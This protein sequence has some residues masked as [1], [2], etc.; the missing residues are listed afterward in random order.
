MVIT[1]SLGIL[2]M[3]LTL[4]VFGVLPGVPQSSS[5]TIIIDNDPPYFLASKTIAT[6]GTPIRWENRTAFHHAIIYDAC[7]AGSPCAF[8]V[9]SIAPNEIYTLQGLPPGRYAYHCRLHPIM[10]G[11][12][13]VVDPFAYT[14]M[15]HQ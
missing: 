9:E 14:T 4:F 15:A 11:E 1:M 3:F 7:V 10:R 12:V 8:V 2:M 13:V 6:S 5:V